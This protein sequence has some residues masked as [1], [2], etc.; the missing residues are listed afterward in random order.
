MRGVRARTTSLAVVDGTRVRV[1][2]IATRHGKR[3][4]G[5]AAALI[6]LLVLARGIPV[7]Y[8]LCVCVFIPHNG[9]AKREEKL[10][11]GFGSC[12]SFRELNV[13]KNST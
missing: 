12:L 3:A 6:G 2:V 11:C 10:K 5:V 9:G 4:A 1:G 13:P 7:A 8:R